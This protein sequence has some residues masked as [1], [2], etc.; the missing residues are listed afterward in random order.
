MNRIELLKKRD[1]YIFCILARL[2]HLSTYFSGATASVTEVQRGNHSG[3]GGQGTHRELTQEWKYVSKIPSPRWTG[4]E[5]HAR[6][7]PE[8]GDKQS[9]GKIRCIIS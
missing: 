2:K 1:F 8:S 4:R 9:T 6:G 7:D 3:Q 5:K